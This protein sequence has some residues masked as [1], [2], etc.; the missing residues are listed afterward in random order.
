MNIIA[1]D[2]ERP[3]LRM[4]E[5]AIMEVIPDCTLACFSTAADALKYAKETTIDIA[6][7]D[8]HMPGISGLEFAKALTD[9]YA[10]TNI[11][12]ITGYAEHAIEAFS[13]G[14]SGYIVK[15]PDPESITLELGRLRY[16]IQ[17]KPEQR[18]RIK[19]FGGFGVFID[20]KPLHIPWNNPKELLAYL[21][22]KQGAGVSTAEIAAILWEDKEYNR[23]LQ[24]QT[25]R[26]ISQLLKLLD[27]AGIG[28]IVQKDW[29]SMAVVPDNFSCDYYEHLSN[30]SEFSAINSGEYMVDYSWGEATAGYLI[31]KK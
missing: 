22:H 20:G 4:L 12:F 24:A 27:D 8:I 11:L 3:A 16:P 1:V 19:C 21:V 31:N 26:V 30:E 10:K 7:L 6:F 5:N 14:A 9:I 17:T 23:S 28:N 15:P 25:Q 13:M 18:V 29:N 2:D